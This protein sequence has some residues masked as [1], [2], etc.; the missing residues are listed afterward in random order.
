LQAT[1][2]RTMHINT[3]YTYTYIIAQGGI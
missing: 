3:L 1:N 2:V